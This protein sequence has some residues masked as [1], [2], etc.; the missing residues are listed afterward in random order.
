MDQGWLRSRSQQV[1][2][3]NISSAIEVS[4]VC[5]VPP[6][7]IISRMSR[8]RVASWMVMWW[9]REKSTSSVLQPVFVLLPPCFQFNSAHLKSKIIRTYSLR[10]LLHAAWSFVR[11]ALLHVIWRSAARKYIPPQKKKRKKTKQEWSRQSSMTRLRRLR[12]L[13]PARHAENGSD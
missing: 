10:S 7:N 4:D 12:V 6:Y 1:W 13:S 3:L 11:E 9:W 5:W 8:H 2:V